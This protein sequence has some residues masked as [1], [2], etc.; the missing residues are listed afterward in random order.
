M[1]TDFHNSFTSKLLYFLINSQLHKIRSVPDKLQSYRIQLQDIKAENCTYR[2]IN[3][4]MSAVSG[5]ERAQCLALLVHTSTDSRY[6][7]P[8]QVRSFELRVQTHT[9]V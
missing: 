1:F 2:Y 9:H 7:S 8:Q 4:H 6:N 3:T 5:A